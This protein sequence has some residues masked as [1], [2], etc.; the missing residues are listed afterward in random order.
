MNNNALHLLLELNSIYLGGT[1]SPLEIKGENL[2]NWD[3]GGV[4]LMD[5]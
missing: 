3:H 4:S 1:G 5:S 2:S